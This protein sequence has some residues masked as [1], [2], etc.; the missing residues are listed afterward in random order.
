MPQKRK[1]RSFF[2]TLSATPLFSIPAFADSAKLGCRGKQLNALAKVHTSR[3]TTWLKRRQKG[4]LHAVNARLR[5]VDLTVRVPRSHPSL[6][7]HARCDA[8]M[9]ELALLRMAMMPCL[10]PLDLSQ[11]KVIVKP[12]RSR[13]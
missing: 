10:S 4:R 11:V 5:E 2:V 13:G 12:L 8:V 7:P 1:L 3:D 9:P 6:S